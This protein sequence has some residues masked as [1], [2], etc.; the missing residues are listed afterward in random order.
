MQEKDDGPNLKLT[1]AEDQ[2]FDDLPPLA[3]D[4]LRRISDLVRAEISI[5]STGPDRS[6]TIIASAI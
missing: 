3:K 4:Y 5:I 1:V 2:E 6:E